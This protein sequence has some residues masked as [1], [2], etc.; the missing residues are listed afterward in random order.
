MKKKHTLS[1]LCVIALLSGC[2]ENTTYNTTSTTIGTASTLDVLNAGI[3][4]ENGSNDIIGTMIPMQ[5]KDI[6]KDFSYLED[7]EVDIDISGLSG[8]MA[9][10]QVMNMT[11]AYTE[12]TGKSVKISGEYYAQ[13][14]P[15]LGKHIIC[16]CY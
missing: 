1:I 3:S 2:G 10:A 15:E 5:N 4:A 9:Y 11:Y 14:I 6:D 13:H 7:V 12:Y 16:Y 8:T